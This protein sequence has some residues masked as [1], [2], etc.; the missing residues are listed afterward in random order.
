MEMVDVI[1]HGTDYARSYEDKLRFG[2]LVRLLVWAKGMTGKSSAEITSAI[3]RMS[4][5]SIERSAYLKM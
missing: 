3:L 5:E 2:C 1:M 4:K